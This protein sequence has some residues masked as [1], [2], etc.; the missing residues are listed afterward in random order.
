MTS[1]ELERLFKGLCREKPSQSHVEKLTDYPDRDGLVSFLVEKLAH[2][3]KITDTQDKWDSD[4]EY[5][6]CHACRLLGDFK[7]EQATPL[8]IELL[9]SVKDQYLAILY[10]SALLALE[11]MGP[12]ALEPA[13]EK[14]L[15]D[16]HDPE[17][18][19]V[20]VWVLGTIGVRDERIKQALLDH[21]EF[22]PDEAILL[23]GDYGDRDLLPLV[24]SYVTYLAQY[25]NAGQIDPFRYGARL[26]DH[27]VGSYIDNRESL[28]ML[29]YGIQLDDPEFDVKVKELD[30]QLLQH[31]DFAYFPL[32][33]ISD[34][35]SG[36]SEKIGRNDPCP[37]GSGKKYKKC[38]GK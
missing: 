11:G 12:S 35:G 16:K 36:P 31:S 7:A 24:E 14:Y 27:L 13:Y 2:F 22:D 19:S 17:H 3:L 23:M 30:R 37:C 38:C 20:W 15:L 9:D 25:L 8:I 33:S 29:K 32:P 18:A 4:L 5:G 26:G 28:V 1:K 6:I 10:S 34:R 21:M